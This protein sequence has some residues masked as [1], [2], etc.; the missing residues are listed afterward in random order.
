MTD[1]DEPSRDE[2]TERT[3]PETPGGEATAPDGR[4]DTGAEGDTGDGE[5]TQGRDETPD[6]DPD[7]DTDDEWPPGSPDT[8]TGDGDRSASDTAV[9]ADDEI[10]PQ[11]L[12]DG[13]SPA[14]RYGR[15]SDEGEPEAPTGDAAGSAPE[16]PS[17]AAG[18]G[19]HTPPQETRSGD[20][21]AEQPPPDRSRRGEPVGEAATG[22]R[23]GTTQQ[24]GATPPAERRPV[25]D[26][27]PS[28]RT[29]E[30]GLG[31]PVSVLVSAGITGLLSLFGGIIPVLG[32]IFVTLGPFAGGAAGGY[33]RGDDVKEGALVGGAG[34][35]AVLVP[36]GLLAAALFGLGFVASV[37]GG[38]PA[39]AVGSF[40][41]AVIGLVFAAIYVAI[42]AVGGF[43]GSSVSDRKRPG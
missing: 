24:P 16:R 14:E 11:L 17:G 31:R 35:C 18:H 6:E 43:V 2:T 36:L 42:G 26:R 27:P 4:E 40:L 13:E 5:T 22:S 21:R 3:D 12:D 7:T 30:E 38:D 37:S 28:P 29:V 34:T 1:S 23:R 32:V 41:F 9:D 33:L 25:A 20:G 39:G 10:E 8:E 19:S 15:F